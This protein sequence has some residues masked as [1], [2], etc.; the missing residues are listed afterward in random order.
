[1]A[2]QNLL[3]SERSIESLNDNLDV[4]LKT[5]IKLQTASDFLT[6]SENEIV[7]SFEPDRINYL[8]NLPQEDN[9]NILQEKSKIDFICRYWYKKQFEIQNSESSSTFYRNYRPLGPY[10]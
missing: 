6:H 2:Y 10:R 4:L 9:D 1:M 3:K 5:F 7:A 8:R